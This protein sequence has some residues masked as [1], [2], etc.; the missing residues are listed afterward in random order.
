MALVTTDNGAG[1]F[2]CCSFRLSHIVTYIN[3]RKQLPIHVDSSQQFA[4]YKRHAGEDVTAEIFA[5]PDPRNPI[6][7]SYIWYHWMHQTRMYRT[8]DFQQLCPLVWTYFVPSSA[9]QMLAAQIVRHYGIC[10]ET[11][12]GVYYRGTDK[13]KETN[14]DTY[15]RFSSKLREVFDPTKHTSVLVQTDTQQFL[16]HMQA[17]WTESPIHVVQELRTS[18]GQLGIHNESSSQENFHDIQHLLAVVTI[19]SACHTILCTTGNVSK[20]IVLYRGTCEH[21]F[22]NLECKWV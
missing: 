16:E 11:C 5:Q 12:V 2:S 1:F 21:V 3:A 8:L 13:Y 19:L 20:W 9:V 4:M 22:Q 10:V 6:V 14:I 17:V 7:Y 18:N 15:E